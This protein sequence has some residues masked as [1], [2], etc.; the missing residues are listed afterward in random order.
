MGLTPEEESRK[1]MIEAYRRAVIE[2]AVNEEVMA[3]TAETRHRIIDRVLESIGVIERKAA[4][5]DAL[6]ASLK[7]RE[8]SLVWYDPEAGTVVVREGNDEISRIGAHDEISGVIES[9]QQ[10]GEEV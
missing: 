4:A 9:S 10:S 8:A 1:S 3:G 7:Q 5:W 2:K 6:V